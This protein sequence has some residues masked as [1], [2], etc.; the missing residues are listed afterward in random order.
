MSECG[1]GSTFLGKKKKVYCNLISTK[2]IDLMSTWL[3]DGMIDFTTLIHQF[4]SF[5]AISSCEVS[6]ILKPSLLSSW[7][8]EDFI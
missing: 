8:M 4:Q 6:H 5:V 2:D 7:P 3:I 1:T